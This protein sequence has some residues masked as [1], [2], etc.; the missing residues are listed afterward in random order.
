MEQYGAENRLPPVRFIEA[1]DIKTLVA[2]QRL[3]LKRMR[4]SLTAKMA[5]AAI[6]R[7]NRTELGIA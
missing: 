4:A 7:A 6:D 2:V 5:L 3:C 1:A